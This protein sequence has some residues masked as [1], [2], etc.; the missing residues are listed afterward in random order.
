MLTGVCFTVSGICPVRGT[1]LLRPSTLRGMLPAVNI[2]VTLR[3]I[4][5]DG[6]SLVVHV[7]NSD[8]LAHLSPNALILIKHPWDKKF[9][10]F[11]QIMFLGSYKWP[12]PKDQNA[13]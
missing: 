10:S 8:S 6:R 7:V 4:V 5:R 2:Y 9:S 11:G 3:L 12:H 1:I 13:F